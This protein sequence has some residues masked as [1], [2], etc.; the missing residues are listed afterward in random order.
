MEVGQLD[1]TFWDKKEKQ[2]IITDPVF[3]RQRTIPNTRAS[4]PR[5]AS[6]DLLELSTIYINGKPTSKQLQKY[7][8]LKVHPEIWGGNF[9]KII[10][11]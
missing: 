1:N 6:N 5:R 9:D 7:R 11:Y 3:A 4:K 10:F 2:Q 8:V